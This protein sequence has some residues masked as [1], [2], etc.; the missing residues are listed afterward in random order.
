MTV[1]AYRE[2]IPRTFTHKF[3]ESP[4][5]ER[6]FVVT[7][8]SPTPTQDVI[9]S[10]GILHLD[11][12]PEYSY[13]RMLDASVSESD[14]HH[15]EVSFKY[16]APKQQDAEPNPLARADVWTFSTGGAQVPALTYYDGTTRKP[17]VNAAGD[18]FEGLTAMEAEVRATISGNRTE[19]PLADAAAVTN[20][21]NSGTYLGGAAHTWQ[22]AGITGQQATEVVNGAEV[23]YWEI[24]VQLV[25]R[26]SGWNLQLPHVGWHYVNSAG[27]PKYRTFVRNDD[28][29]DGPAA[30]PQPLT[31]TGSQK[32]TGGTSGPPD[33]LV[34]RIYPEENF[35]DYFGTP[36]F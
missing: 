32:Y 14:R 25:Y 2:V 17:L 3:G 19:F 33:I 9:S 27:G 15:V 24:S 4:T 11:S 13:L 12:H 35:S 20:C 1:I 30:T 28:G 22:C 16:E 26:Q 21:L 8:D 18:Y 6:K 7:V 23:R 10:V 36:P 34:R 31:E 5:A 29:T